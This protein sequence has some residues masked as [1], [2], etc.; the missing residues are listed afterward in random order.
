MENH[1]KH[2]SRFYKKK[3]KKSLVSISSLMRSGELKQIIKWNNYLEKQSEKLTQ[4][5]YYDWEVLKKILSFEEN[6]KLET[7]CE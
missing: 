3:K 6:Y 4:E 2:V 1:A 5:E 7:D